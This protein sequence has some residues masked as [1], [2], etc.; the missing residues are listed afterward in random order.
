MYLAEDAWTEGEVRQIIQYLKQRGRWPAV[1]HLKLFTLISVRRD[2]GFPY[3]VRCC[4]SNPDRSPPLCIW[5]ITGKNCLPLNS[6]RSPTTCEV[7]R[8]AGEA[9]QDPDVLPQ[10]RHFPNVSVMPD[11]RSRAVTTFVHSLACKV[12]RRFHSTTPSMM[13]LTSFRIHEISSS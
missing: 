7:Q 6:H 8:A 2:E 13:L 4:A 5:Y 9:I 3:G 1:F 12:D 11:V 10:G